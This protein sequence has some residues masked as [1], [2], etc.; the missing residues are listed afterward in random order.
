M[1]LIFKS[2]EKNCYCFYFILFF[3]TPRALYLPFF[4]LFYSI[5]FSLLFSSILLH[6]T[7]YYF[8]LLY[9]TILSSRLGLSGLEYLIENIQKK[10]TS[11]Y[12][13]KFQDAPKVFNSETN[14]NNF[15]INNENIKDII[16]NIEG[17][18]EKDKEREKDIFFDTLIPNPAIKYLYKELNSIMKVLVKKI[19]DFQSLGRDC[20]GAGKGGVGEI[21]YLF[22]HNLILPR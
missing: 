21:F 4:N 14:L 3:Y 22:S 7:L 2:V 1:K 19:I 17:E 12:M 18:K 15:M 5:I 10:V 16:E 20:R 13:N 11:A 8:T 6:F 9:F